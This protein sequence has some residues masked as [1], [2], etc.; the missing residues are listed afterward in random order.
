MS[1]K[2]SPLTAEQIAAMDEANLTAAER[3]AIIDWWH[4]LIEDQAYGGKTHYSMPPVRGMSP[5]G[6]FRIPKDVIN[7]LGGPQSGGFIVHHMFG[8]QDTPRRPDRNPPPCRAHYWRRFAKCRTTCLRKIRP[9][10]A[11]KVTR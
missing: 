9:T 11:P 10:S 3:D 7:K 6:S 2:P 8:I 4:G 5:P 1:N